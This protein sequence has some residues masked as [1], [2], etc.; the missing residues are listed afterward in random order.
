MYHSILFQT[1]LQ[2]SHQGRFWFCLG[3]QKGQTWWCWQDVFD[4]SLQLSHWATLGDQ[5]LSGSGWRNRE[6]KSIRRILQC[7]RK[8]LRRVNRSLILQRAIMHTLYIYKLIRTDLSCSWQR[9]KQCRWP[10]STLCRRHGEQIWCGG[11]H[12]DGLPNWQ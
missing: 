12:F 2:Y 5:S 7:L 6:M 4:R 3:S 8:I 9:L 11:V 1:V 10:P